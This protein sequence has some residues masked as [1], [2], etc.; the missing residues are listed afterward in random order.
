MQ[1]AIEK[2]TKTDTDRVLSFVNYMTG[3]GIGN[4]S[5]Q[6]LIDLAEIEKRNREGE[7]RA[8]Y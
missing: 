8:G 6:N 3:L 5:K 4:V 2:G 1:R 7:Q